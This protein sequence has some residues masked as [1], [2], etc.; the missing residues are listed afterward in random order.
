M[1][2]PQ[3]LFPP[4]WSRGWITATRFWRIYR[5]QRWHRSR[6][7]S[8]LLLGWSWIWDHAITWHRRYTSFTGCQ[9]QRE[10]SSNSVSWSTIR[11]MTEHRLIWPSCGHIR[12]LRPR[13][14]FSPFIGRHDLVVPRSRLVSSEWAFSAA[15]PRTWNSLPVDIRLITDTKLFKKKL[16]T[17]FFQSGLSHNIPMIVSV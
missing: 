12:G 6:E 1:T 15:A 17:Y 9:L 10:S 8:M 13:S 4:L 16:K 11:S 2:S 7:S 5:L 3:D 14:R